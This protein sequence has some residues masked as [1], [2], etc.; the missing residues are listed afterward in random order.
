MEF[1]PFSNSFLGEFGCILIG[2]LVMDFIM[3]EEIVS[4][5][6][7][8]CVSGSDR[9]ERRWREKKR[10]KRGGG[11]E[12]KGRG[13]KRGQGRSDAETQQLCFV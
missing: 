3:K 10:G 8:M 9:G 7:F 4:F 5:D 11:R 13:L 1:R 12:G 6:V 2:P